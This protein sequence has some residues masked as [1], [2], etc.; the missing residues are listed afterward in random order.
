[1]ITVLAF[2]IQDLLHDRGRALIH[3]LGVSLV[4]AS[5]LLLA[6]FSDTLTDSMQQMDASHNLVILQDGVF[7]LTD[8]YVE[9]GLLRAIQPIAPSMIDRVSPV[10]FRHMR[11]D[12]HV[13]Q[14]R[15]APLADW[16]KVF[17]LELLEGHW[18][19]RTGQVAIGEGAAEGLG[20]QVG[21]PLEIYG[22]TFQ[23]TGVFRSPGTKFASVWMDLPQA[24]RLFDLGE[25]FSA[26]YAS[27]A[28]GIDPEIVRRQ[29]QSDPLLSGRYVVYLEDGLIRRSMQ[30]QRDIVSLS[31]IAGWIALLGVTLGI[32]SA[33]YLSLAERSREFGLLRSIGFSRQ[34]IRYFLLVRALI[35]STFGFLLGL[36]VVSLY[37]SSILV[38]SNPVIF[39]LPLTIQMSLPTL[40]V[41]VTLVALMCL[42][43]V[44]LST[45][46]LDSHSVAETLLG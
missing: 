2:A 1:M 29:L 45:R 35:L 24:Q 10:L 4:I 13:V 19:V 43:G 34:T 14:L 23:V 9:P 3:G 32:Y 30:A 40:T 7:D 42:L 31:R 46:Q 6:G 12:N 21:S 28:F 44:W 33:T 22:S 18:P 39:G 16:E 17:G 11:I 5:Y 38:H 8:A 41:G 36:G 27:L 15:A 20:W 25:R 37:S 26:V